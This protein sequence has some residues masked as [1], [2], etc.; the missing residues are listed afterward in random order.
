MDIEGSELDVMNAA[1]PETLRR[2]E[3]FGMEYH[4][5]LVPGTL[6][7]LQQILAATHEMRVE[8]TPHGHGMLFAWLKK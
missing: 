4:D 8:P 7:R 1:T 3:R 2:I 6:K 5:N